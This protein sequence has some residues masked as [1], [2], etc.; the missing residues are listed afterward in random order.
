MILFCLGYATTHLSLTLAEFN[1]AWNEKL[2]SARQ[3]LEKAAKPRTPGSSQTPSASASVGGSSVGGAAA[4]SSESQGSLSK[5]EVHALQAQQRPLSSLRTIA[6]VQTL[7]QL[8]SAIFAKNLT[9][10][11]TSS[12]V[13]R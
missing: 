10:L 11:F 2:G 1:K 3:T 7:I 6:K 13:S 4:G 12:P 8:K 9:D 5:S